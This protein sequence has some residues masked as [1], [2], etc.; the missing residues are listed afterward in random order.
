[1]TLIKQMYTDK[2]RGIKITEKKQKERKEKIFITVW[3]KR[4][5]DFTL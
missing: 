5:N 3:K 4:K 1:M 2:L